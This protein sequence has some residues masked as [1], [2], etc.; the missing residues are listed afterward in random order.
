MFKHL[1]PHFTGGLGKRCPLPA[2]PT[3]WSHPA[4][5]M[6]G[7]RPERGRGPQATSP[8]LSPP[9]Q[10]RG[11]MCSPASP[12]APPLPS[13]P[14]GSPGPPL[15]AGATSDRAA[16]NKPGGGSLP[17]S[18]VWE[19]GAWSKAP[20]PGPRTELGQMLP[21]GAALERVFLKFSFPLTFSLINNFLRLQTSD[22]KLTP[23]VLV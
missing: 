2:T 7:V 6:Q 9:L 10:K 12:P 4:P 17:G 13:L 14:P 11:G 1:W 15:S 20:R 22:G 23:R 16:Q 8:L 18:T 19:R 21:L 5:C 3:P